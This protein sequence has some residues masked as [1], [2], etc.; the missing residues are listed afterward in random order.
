M[1]A[2]L[3][4]AGVVESTVMSQHFIWNPNGKKNGSETYT[5]RE[6]ML[7]FPRFVLFPFNIEMIIH[8]PEIPFKYPI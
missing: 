6:R 7:D 5:V 2:P 3:Q 1:Q 8:A 4:G